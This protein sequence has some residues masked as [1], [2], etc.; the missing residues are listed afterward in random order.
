[1]KNKLFLKALCLMFVC[2]LVAS[3]ALPASA[4]LVLPQNTAKRGL[5]M[6]NEYPNGYWAYMS[7]SYY[8]DL[9]I[10]IRATQVE[11]KAGMITTVKVE[12]A[13]TEEAH[14]SSSLGCSAT[15][16]LGF[17]IA[18]MAD[19]SLSGTLSAELEV[20]VA[21]SYTASTSVSFTLGENYEPGLYRIN[22]VFPRRSVLKRVTAIDSNNVETT[23]WSERVTYAPRL[24]DA[25]WACDRYEI[26][27]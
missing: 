6:T 18:E 22:I 15:A 12:T 23:L 7:T 8:S 27:S 11:H 16:E 20:G 24:N 3:S 10:P 1:M 26:G 25:H 13:V 14:A 17:G 21:V 2:V 9:E 19:V 4:A 5:G